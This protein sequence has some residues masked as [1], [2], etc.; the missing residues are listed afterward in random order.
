MRKIATKLRGGLAVS[1]PVNIALPVV[2]GAEE[3]GKTLTATSGVW[4][5]APTNFSYKWTKFGA[6][7]PGATSSTYTPVAGDIGNVISVTVTAS[8]SAG[9]VAASSRWIAKI[10]AAGVAV[11][12]CS[13]APAL[14]T[15]TPRSGVSISISNGTWTN[16][17]VSFAYQ[18]VYPFLGST[19][20]GQPIVGATSSTY[21]PVTA[22][23]GI[24]IGCMVTA[25]NGSG[26][27]ASGLAAPSSLVAAAPGLTIS[28]TAQVGQTLTAVGGAAPYQ[29]SREGS[30]ISGATSSTYVLQAADLSCLM[31][32]KAA[33]VLSP[34]AG[35][36]IG[37]T[38]RYVS[39]TDGLDTNDGTTSTPGAP[40]GPWKTIA[41][42]NS[43][44]FAPGTSVLFKRGDK[45][46]RSGGPSVLNTIRPKSGG[47]SGNPIVYDAYGT[48]ANPIIDGSADGLPNGAA[49]WT[50]VGTNIWQSVQTFPPNAGFTNGKQ[51]FDANDVGNILWGFSPLGGSAPPA[52]NKASYGIMKGGGW[53]G[54]WYKPGDGTA[55]LGTTQGNWNFN[56]DNWRVQIYSVGNPNTTMPGLRLVLDGGGYVLE[57]NAS[58]TTFQNITFQYI[59]GSVCCVSRANNVITRDCVLQWIGGGNIGGGSN[60]GSRAGDGWEQ[61]QTFTNNL[62]ERN[63]VYQ[64]YDIGIAPQLFTA[65][66]HDNTIV[67]N[68][69]FD[70]FM[71]AL[72]PQP[73]STGTMNG[74]Y[75]YNNT[76]Y[77]VNSWSWNQRPNGGNAS[78]GLRAAPGGAVLSNFTMVNNVFA[79]LSD[80]GIILSSMSDS[81]AA[82]APAQIDYNDWKLLTGTGILIAST[83]PTRTMSAWRTARGFE[84]HGL[85]DIDPAFTSASGANYAPAPGSPLLNAGNNLF[86]LGVVWDFNH[87]PRPSSGPFTIGAFQ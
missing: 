1:M 83:D 31:Q 5:G 61:Q 86:S 39:I 68:N 73:G 4:T 15:S 76:C 75:F 36:V 60:N 51:Y 38:V 70:H 85:I 63:Y 66:A 82:Y 64:M 16:S 48:G 58:F 34:L 30:A 49:S 55:N 22:D 80:Y 18:W 44:T 74:I 21:T 53:G 25:S 37:T 32:V 47:T 14:S 41:K 78:W 35:P 13:A 50:N 71:Q 20:G 46:D 69:V 33:G 59:G 26:A 24:A 43:Q 52:V 79:G 67:R 62:V 87:K 6:A 28:G 54:V 29:W 11:P 12:V 17:P 40:H 9:S 84:T 27:G 72:W 2:T 7:I 81:F 56:T 10:S 65:G 8:N 23:A 42:V 19:F 57:S 77:G 3:V 45:W